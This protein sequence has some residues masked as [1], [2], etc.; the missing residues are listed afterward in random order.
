GE[1]LAEAPQ[2]LAHA[3]GARALRGT[4]DL[5]EREREAGGEDERRSDQA[6]ELEQPLVEARVLE[7]RGEQEHDRVALDHEE[8]G[9]A[10]QPVEGLDALLEPWPHACELSP[11]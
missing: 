5:D 7:R 8:Q 1:H 2:R 6:V 4:A 9:D 3:L 10:T 11:P